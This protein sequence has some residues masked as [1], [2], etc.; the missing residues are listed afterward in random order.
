MTKPDCLLMG[1]VNEHLQKR[2]DEIVTVHRY[3]EADDKGA[4]LKRIEPSTRIVVTG[5]GTGCSADVINALPDLELIASFGVGYDAVDVSAARAA[6]VR[7]TNTPD[8]LND[9]V[10]EVA[11]TLMLGLCHRLPQSDR[12]VRSGRWAEEGNMPLLRN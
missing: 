4:L 6:G 12:Y 3:W 8:V 11:L 9:C 7:V 5:G 10:A 1:P 2:L